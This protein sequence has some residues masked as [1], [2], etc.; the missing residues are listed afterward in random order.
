MGFTYFLKLPNVSTTIGQEILHL[1][2]LDQTKL[3]I[4]KEEK[5]HA[6][7]A[8][9][10]EDISLGSFL[11]QEGTESSIEVWRQRRH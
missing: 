11:T 5:T 7:S 1:T 8:L 4:W 2:R 6:C 10:S 9:S 3:I